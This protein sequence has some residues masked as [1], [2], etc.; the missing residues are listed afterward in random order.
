M[1]K[2]IDFHRAS[3]RLAT[4]TAI[5]PPGRYGAVVVKKDRVAS[6]TE[7]PAGDG[8]WING[9]Y[10][11]LE[12]KAIDYIDND[13]SSWESDQLVRLCRDDQVAAYQHRGF[14]QAM[15]TLRD[16]SQLEALWQSGEA[17][18]KVWR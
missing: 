7:K 3:T 6:F 10:F 9:G 15:D 2:L 17:P 13:A 4:L 14:W 11:V 8:S 16:K 12:P 18:W 5:Q 1:G